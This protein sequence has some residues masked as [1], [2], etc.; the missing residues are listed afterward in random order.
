MCGLNCLRQKHSVHQIVEQ[1]V[2]H[3]GQEEQNVGGRPLPRAEI[4]RQNRRLAAIRLDLKR[5]IRKKTAPK[6]KVAAKLREKYAKERFARKDDPKDDGAS[7][8]AAVN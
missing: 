2:V 6:I 4:Q 7:G 3:Q 1:P 8:A 5:P